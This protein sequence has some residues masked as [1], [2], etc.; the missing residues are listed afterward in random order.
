MVCPNCGKQIPDGSV[1]C[2]ECGN[3]TN[4]APA[5]QATPVPAVTP[6]TPVS[7]I[8]YFTKVAP[9]P[10]RI[11]AAIALG[12][13]ILSI[14]FVFLSAN[15]AVNGSMLKIPVVSLVLD[16]ADEMQDELDEAVRAL[17]KFDTEELE[18]FLHEFLGVTVDSEEIEAKKS[19]ILNLF[20]PFSI[21]SF[22][23]LTEM[24]GQD[25]DDIS[26]IVEV[27][28]IVISV[29]WIYAVVLMIL[30]AL[31]VLF[32]K[33]WLMVLA[34]ILGLAF[35]AMTG[36]VVLVILA[37]VAYI[38]TAVLFSKMKGEYKAF[39]AACVTGR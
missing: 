27:F 3:A 21:N 32:Q 25:D 15:N 28:S 14:L 38:A 13:G 5:P 22:I 31:G 26:E 34:Y 33:T 11:R 37:T 6:N 1:F 8:Q 4:A 17:K 29:V 20:S 12:L 9:K 7:K 2:T 16:D 35:I 39:K 36:G 24:F 23:E 18:D 30:T 19:K 10:G